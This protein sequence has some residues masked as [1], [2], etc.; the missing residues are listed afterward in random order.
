MLQ[1]GMLC[2][3]SRVS[4]FQKTQNDLCVHCGLGQIYSRT[5]WKRGSCGRDPINGYNT[6][7]DKESCEEPA[8]VTNED[9]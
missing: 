2:Y 3:Y 8:G 1:I 7:K 9:F 6:G 5:D 4:A